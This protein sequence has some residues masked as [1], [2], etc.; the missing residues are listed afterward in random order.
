[1]K[2]LG[3]SEISRRIIFRITYRVFSFCKEF[4]E[5]SAAVCHIGHGKIIGICPVI[6]LHFF[7]HQREGVVGG[8][9]HGSHADVKKRLVGGETAVTVRRGVSVRFFHSLCAP[10]GTPVITDL[11]FSAEVFHDLDQFS[12]GNVFIISVIK[13][14]INIIR[15]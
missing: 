13:I 7:I 11:S 1:M 8:R 2:S 9:I 3:S 5:K 10:V 6:V 4:V 14:K 15:A 12:R